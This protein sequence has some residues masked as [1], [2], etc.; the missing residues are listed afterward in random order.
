MISE[1]CSHLVFCP[2]AKLCQR[3]SGSGRQAKYPLRPG[4]ATLHFQC[5]RS[6]Q[7][8]E[9]LYC[10]QRASQRPALQTRVGLTPATT[11]PK[12]KRSSD[13]VHSLTLL[14][15][16]QAPKAFPNSPQLHQQSATGSCPNTWQA[17]GLDMLTQIRFTR[18][19]ECSDS[20]LDY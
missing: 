11:R 10:R 20:R 7:L 16:Q 15:K 6:A 12:A 8:L 3:R 17:I 18:N 9:S 4:L 2:L 1:C 14:A 13:S 5:C 19:G